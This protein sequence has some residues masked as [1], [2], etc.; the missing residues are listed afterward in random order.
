MTN[1]LIRLFIKNH[2]AVQDPAV[3]ESYGKFGGLVGIVC[4]LFLC[5]VKIIT[6]LLSGGISMVADGLNNLSDMGSSVITMIGFKMAGKPADSDHPFGHGRMEYVSAFV[7]AI[8]I[9]VVGIELLLTSLKS[10]FSGEAAPV[11]SVL[12]LILLGVSIPVKLWMF[13]FNRKLGRLIDSGTLLATAQD[14]VNDAI[15]TAAILVAAIVTRFVTLPFSLDAVIACGVALFILWSGISTA[16]DPMNAILGKPIP[17]E[18][19]R[20]LADII[21]S[22]DE[23]VGIHDLMVHDYGAGRQFASVHV[24]VPQDIDIVHCHEQI[25]LCEK[26]VAEKTGVQLV[27]HMDPIDVNDEIVGQTR[28]DMAAVLQTIDARMTLHDFRMTPNGKT[29][30]NLIFDVVLPAEKMAEK[31]HIRAQIA[32]KARQLDPTFCC[33]ITFD[34]D[35]TDGRIF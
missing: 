13:L 9:L 30:T 2:T 33:V 15:A 18:L 35:F 21:L 17:A 20:E 28:R 22:F 25:D 29:R 4:N 16:R 7:V 34:P 32:Q 5:L 31:E 11:Y 12:A 8:L 26:L 3:R 10:L 6:G 24:E 19:V 14:S 27:I 1:L 23:F